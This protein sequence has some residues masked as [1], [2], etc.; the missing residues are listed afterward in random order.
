MKTKVFQI[1]LTEQFLQSDQD[2]LNDFLESITLKKSATELVQSEPKYWSIF[3]Y[4]EESE[5]THEKFREKKFISPLDGK[6]P[7]LSQNRKSANFKDVEEMEI[8]LSIQEIARLESLK[9]WR[10]D[11]ANRLNLPGYMVT[12]NATLINVSK[13][14]PKS[15]DELINIKGLGTNKIEKYGN[16]IIALLNSI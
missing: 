12:S 14:N 8:P 6:L 9:L 13:A 1:R 2:A 16:D 7:V 10:N 5:L 3:L 11:I 15:T 4:Y